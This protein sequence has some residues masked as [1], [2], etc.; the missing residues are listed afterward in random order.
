MKKINKKMKKKFFKSNFH[1]YDLE[2][3]RTKKQIIKQGFADSEVWN[4][5]ETIIRFTLPRLKRLKEIQHG[6]PNGLNEEK[7]DKILSEIIECIE[8]YLGRMNYE[9]EEKDYKRI[10]K[11]FKLFGKYLPDLWD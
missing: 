9:F 4:L 5:D 8:M 7:W 11:A 3:K 10:K 6:Y 2:N 1:G